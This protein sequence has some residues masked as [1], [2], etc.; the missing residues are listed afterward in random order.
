MWGPAAHGVRRT[1]ADHSRCASFQRR[2]SNGINR[3]R[4]GYDGPVLMRRLAVFSTGLLLAGSLAAC[5]GPRASGAAASCPPSAPAPVTSASSSTAGAGASAVKGEA[6]EAP[7][8]PLRRCFPDQPAWVDAA[9]ADL[10]DHAA[11]LFDAGDYVGALA[12]AEEA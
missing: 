12:C 4:F 1:R 10:L 11:D 2:S 8:R 9:V 6:V 3:V 5:R 7:P